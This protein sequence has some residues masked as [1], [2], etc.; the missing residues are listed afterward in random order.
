MFYIFL[1]VI[2]GV[3]GQLFLKQ[4]ML[5][6]GEFPQQISMILNYYSKVIICHYI[7]FGF[8][9]Y[10]L[11][12]LIWLGVLSKVELS[13]ARPVVAS[14]YI[15]IALFSWALWDENLSVQRLIGIIFIT[16]GV[17]LVAKS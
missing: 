6:V 13:Y 15:L 9:S 7:W 4:G 1:S 17:I 3:V 14:G 11:S 10:G 12:F 5:K 8:I 2:L 16:I